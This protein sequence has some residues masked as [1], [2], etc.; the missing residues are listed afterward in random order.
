MAKGQRG[1]YDRSRQTK[2]TKT[3]A[4]RRSK[5]AYNNR[6]KRRREALAKYLKKCEEALQ[7]YVATVS[8]I[9]EEISLPGS[10]KDPKEV[11]GQGFN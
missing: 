7:E 8:G 1:V 3:A 6:E 5:D 11:P 9:N 4:Q 10:K 2:A